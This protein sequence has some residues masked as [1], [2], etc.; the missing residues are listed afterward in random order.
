MPIR[1]DRHRI[2][3]GLTVPTELATKLAP[4]EVRPCCP[5]MKKGKGLTPCPETNSR[6]GA[7]AC[8]RRFVNASPANDNPINAKEPGSGTRSCTT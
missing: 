6:R 3:S 1:I 2:E 8:L 4:V 5:H 7:Y